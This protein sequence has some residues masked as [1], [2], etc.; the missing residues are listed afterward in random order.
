MAKNNPVLTKRFSVNVSPENGY[1]FRLM[2]S[3]DAESFLYKVDEINCYN[4][5]SGDD[6][7]FIVGDAELTWKVEAC[8]ADEFQ[9][10]FQGWI[11]LDLDKSQQKLLSSLDFEVDYNFEI[12]VDDEA[13]EQ[14]SDYE[15]V[16]NMRFV[17]TE[18]N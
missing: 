4:E 13:L 5:N 14:D 9:V 6:E 18:I 16:Y 15:L 12:L 2:R 3:L 8:G 1:R 10:G 17:M 11:E 7:I